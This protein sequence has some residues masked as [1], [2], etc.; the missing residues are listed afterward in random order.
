M[1][2]LLTK[3]PQWAEAMNVLAQRLGDSGPEL[4]EKAGG[5][6]RV[7]QGRR[8][9]MVVDVVT[10]RQRRYHQRVLP[11]V[12][13]FETSADTP[14]LAMLADCSYGFPGLR[15]KE[16][17]CIRATA[18]GLVRFG[19]DTGGGTD[20]EIVQRWAN[21]TQDLV[22]ASRLDPYVGAV[23]GIGPALFAYLRMRSGA[24]GIKPDLRIRKALA[25]L[26]LPAPADPVALLVL[27]QAVA[28]SLGVSQLVLDQLLWLE[29]GS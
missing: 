11:M 27:A 1:I 20:D 23:S 6:G 9:A 25:A 16:P 2:D 24:D 29:S 15:Q 4:T 28:E 10:S 21:A 7:Y 3:H 5:Y 19:E 18:S 22:I 26:G 8:A 13:E 17:A 14:A 12:A